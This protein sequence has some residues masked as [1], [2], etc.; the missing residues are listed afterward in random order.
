MSR[1]S[2]KPEVFDRIYAG[3]ADPWAFET[4]P[5]ERDKYADT[6]AQL[7]ERR[8]IHAL[9]LG[10]SIGV[11]TRQLAARCDRLLA[12]DAATAAVTRAR[13]RCDGLAHVT[14]ER[15]VLPGDWP[16]GRF[17][18]ILISEVL[19]FLDPDDIAA[20]ARH[21]VEAA[22]PDCIILLVNWTGATDTPT[23]GDQ[24]ATLFRE[25]AAGFIP[26]AP[27]LRPSYRLDRL[28]RS[29]ACP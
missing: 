7:G 1:Q 23:T 26:R 6:L 15:A 9:E 13:Q 10:C 22:R 14:I 27:V 29:A 19:Y 21:C 12:L 24:A 11:M 18:L 2:W 3:S 20:S 28:D 8:F 16:A 17:D 25:A 4:S 5:Y